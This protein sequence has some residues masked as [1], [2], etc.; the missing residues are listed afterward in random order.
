M[1]KKFEDIIAEQGRLIYTNVGDSMYPAIQPRDLLV[2]EAV[3]RPLKVG[4]VP[5]YLR[6]NGQYVLHRVYKKRRGEYVMK[7]DNRTCIERGITDRHII[8]VLTGVIRDGKTCPVDPP[9]VKNAPSPLPLRV[10]ATFKKRI[11]KK[12]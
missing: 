10:L 12:A 9:R 4:D 3:T 11:R 2:I 1:N 7:G 6:D 5:L 8:G